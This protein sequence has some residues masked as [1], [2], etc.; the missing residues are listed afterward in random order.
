MEMIAPLGEW[1]L[2]G[3]TDSKIRHGALTAD[4]SPAVLRALHVKSRHSMTRFKCALFSW[5]KI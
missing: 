4:A 5:L 1:E 3:L 2:A